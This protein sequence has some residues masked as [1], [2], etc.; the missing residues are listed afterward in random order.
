MVSYEV[1]TPPI[2]LWSRFFAD[3]VDTATARRVTLEIDFVVDLT[4]EVQ[5]SGSNVT[6]SWIPA[7]SN[8]T[9]IL[10]AFY[11]HRNGFPEAVGGFNGA[12]QDKPGSWAAFVVD[13]FSPS[14][15][16]VS[17]KFVQDNI[18]SRKGIGEMLARPGE[19]HVGGQRRISRSGLVDR[20]S[21]RSVSWE[22]RICCQQVS[23]DSS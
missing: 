16:E 14:G 2:T 3:G 6:I 5:R 21:C 7:N 10:L 1:P 13:H 15:V 11:Y 17:S 12:Q 23:P 9:N 4:N 19:I 20:G 8:V 18:L 22:T